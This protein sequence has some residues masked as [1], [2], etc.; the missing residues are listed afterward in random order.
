MWVQK[1]IFF[2]FQQDSNNSISPNF[3]LNQLEDDEKYD[4]ILASS[5][6]F[7]TVKIH[8]FRDPDNCHVIERLQNVLQ[9]Y[10]HSIKTVEFSNCKM[11]ICHFAA[12]LNSLMNLEQLSLYDVEIA[13]TDDFLVQLNLSK[14]KRLKF[15]LCNVK[16]TKLVACLPENVLEC[17]IIQTCIVDRATLSKIFARQLKIVEL[18]FDPYYADPTP[19]Q[20]LKLQRIGLNCNRHVKDILNHQKELVSLDLSRAHIGDEEFLKVLQLHRLTKLKL[21]V[22]RISM[23][24]SLSSLNQLGEL[25]ELSVNY[26]RLEV[27]YARVLATIQLPKLTRLKIKFPRL[28]I[29]T[30]YFVAMARNMPNIKHL[31]ISNQSIG[32]ITIL[33]ESFKQMETLV[34]GCD[35]DS[36]EVVDFPTD[37]IAHANIKD[38]CVYSRFQNN[39]KPLKCQNSIFQLVN[40]L[41]NLQ[42]LKLD[43]V[44][45]GLMSELATILSCH[46]QF[47]HLYF[48]SNLDSPQLEATFDENSLH[49]IATKGCRLK[50]LKLEDVE[51][52]LHKRQ[53]EHELRNKFA[54]ISIKPWRRQITMRNCKWE[55]GDD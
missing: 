6:Q 32:I 18:E 3:L 52:A 43:N 12:L 50:F 49:A 5:R 8:N 55:H 53:V 39:Q 27:E 13:E 37:Q 30:D 28:K 51:L 31:Q 4:S 26:D 44:V 14:L 36:T 35:S 42:K 7:D 11:Q 41:T 24:E 45:M 48:K 40:R 29:A 20:S 9:K 10:H 47:S 15:H 19:I 38:L 23:W 46:P 25:E 34:I 17:L 22:D 16:L 54:I 21:W 2:H 33:L 1:Y